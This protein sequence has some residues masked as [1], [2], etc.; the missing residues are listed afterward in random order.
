MTRKNKVQILK[1]IKQSLKRIKEPLI[2]ER[3]LMVQAS[4]KEPLR[5]AAQT[6]G[7]AHGKVAYWRRRYDSFGLRGLQTKPRSGR[8]SKIS[9]EQAMK[10][11]RKVR[12]HNVTR[13]WQ[14]KMIKDVIKNESGVSYS[15]RQV[16]RIS[17]S[18]GLSQKVARQKYAYAKKENK[19]EFLKK[20]NHS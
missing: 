1:G 19:D 11:R 8:P 14:T 18:W 12:K 9:K 16:I 15:E 5:E 4:Y 6:F 20:T 7:C 13:G 17:Q 3:L 2:R 10:I